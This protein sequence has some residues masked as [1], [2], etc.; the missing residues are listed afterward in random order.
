MILTAEQKCMLWLS[1]AEIAAG[2]VQELMGHYG[3]AEG[4]WDAFDK[5][6]G[7]EFQDHSFQTLKALHSRTAMDDL[8][9][10]LEKKNVH[11]L[12]QS[13][14]AY[15]AQLRVIQDPPYLLYYAGRLS[16]LAMPMIAL[17]GTR[18]ASQYGL[19]MSGLLSRGLCEAGVCV[20]SGL[21]RGIDSAAHQAALN[22][23]G[24]TIGVL[25]SGINVPYPPE[26]TPMLRKIAGGI[27]LIL[28][29]YPLD[30]EPRAFHF[31]HRNRII[32]GLC[33]GVIFVEGRIKSGGMHTVSSALAQGREVF[34][35]PGRIGSY[36]SEGPHIILREGARIVTSA[37]DVLE[38]LGLW[39]EP[40]AN[41]PFPESACSLNETQQAIVQALA[42]E[43]LALSELTQR[44]GIHE[45]ELMTQL[46]MMEILGQVC[47]G[48][49]N[50]FYLP[51]AAEK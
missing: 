24:H 35:V 5:T 18:R 12:F 16:C 13:D 38:D 14:E 21:A 3:T 20:V 49:G 4:I 25:G 33:M 34:A 45:N 17:V 6:G 48:A 31:P 37:Q 28:S 11:L 9:A 42:V 27:G 46:S 43:P 40:S 10:K 47:R 36:G 32:S 41:A 39:R 51:I 50:R 1:S 44:L 30:A 22:C 26:H 23:G 29:E 8:I 2:R 15:P 7:Q 19:E